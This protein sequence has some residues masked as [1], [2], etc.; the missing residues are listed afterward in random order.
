MH[1]IKSFVTHKINEL[2]IYAVSVCLCPVR[3]NRWDI[4]FPDCPS[5][6][7]TLRLCVQRPAKVMPFQQIIMHVLQC[8]HDVDV[9]LYCLDL[10]LHLTHFQGHV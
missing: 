4:M 5:V 2:I 9:L 3:Y 1:P 6:C 7:H 8:S 10:Y